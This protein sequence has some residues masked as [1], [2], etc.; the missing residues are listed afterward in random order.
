M[1]EWEE[2]PHGVTALPQDP[3]NLVK[4]F[5]RKSGGVTP[6]LMHLTKKCS[7]HDAYKIPKKKE[8]KIQSCIS[9]TG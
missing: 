7:Q 1:V 9:W 5:L 6:Y 3:V 8:K 2:G 4:L